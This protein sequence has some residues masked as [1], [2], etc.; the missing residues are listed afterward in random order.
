M[1]RNL[2]PVGI[3]VMLLIFMAGTLAMVNIAAHQDNS[4][5]STTYYE[6]SL[7]YDEIK[8][9]I[10]HRLT[11]KTDIQY[12]YD[13]RSETLKLTFSDSVST[14]KGELHFYNPRNS[15]SDFN[16]EVKSENGI[17]KLSLK[18]V[19]NGLWR[20]KADWTQNEISYYQEFDFL[21]K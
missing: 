14:C 18:D 20:V 7:K 21:K 2:W 6:E 12:L 15:K 5:V 16:V 19:E 4:L 10:E 9:K 11:D 1:K 3:V 13:S 8:N 17:Q